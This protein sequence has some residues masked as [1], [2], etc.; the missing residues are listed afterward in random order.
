LSNLPPW[1]EVRLTKRQTD[2]ICQRRVRILIS[3]G[4]AV[5]V[6]DSMRFLHQS[7]GRVELFVSIAEP[8]LEL[9]VTSNQ[10]LQEQLVC[11]RQLVVPHQT[12]MGDIVQCMWSTGMQCKGHGFH[13]STDCNKTRKK[14]FW[15]ENDGCGLDLR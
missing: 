9:F 4:N 13:M 15:L 6:A 1:R 7:N 5:L 8:F 3:A 14:F 2:R 11:H 10:L 12:R